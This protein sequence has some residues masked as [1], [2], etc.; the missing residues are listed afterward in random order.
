MKPTN[1][2]PVRRRTGAACVDVVIHARAL[3]QIKRAAFWGTGRDGLESGGWC[4]GTWDGSAVHITSATSSEAERGPASVTFDP[5]DLSM[6]ALHEL[7]GGFGRCADWHSH[8]LER[9]AYPSDGDFQAWEASFSLS[10]PEK[11]LQPYYVGLI[12]TA[13]A[14]GRF[15]HPDLSAWAV[16]SEGGRLVREPA[17]VRWA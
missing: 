10:E 6:L 3:E 8:P 17:L 5:G 7:W 11:R 2:V 9:V 4:A 14:D 12:V 13:G 15:V 16:R 1:L